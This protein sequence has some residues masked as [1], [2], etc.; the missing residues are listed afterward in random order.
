M[1]TQQAK[2]LTKC[3]EVVLDDL[4]EHVDHNEETGPLIDELVGVII[5]NLRIELG[6]PER[7]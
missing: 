1:V 6:L 5:P 2:F 7:Q 4:L 3:L